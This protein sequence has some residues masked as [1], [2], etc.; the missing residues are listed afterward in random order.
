MPVIFSVAA[1]K[2]NSIDHN[3]VFNV[4]QNIVIGF[5]CTHTNNQGSGQNLGDGIIHPASIGT[6]GFDASNA[7]GTVT[8]NTPITEATP[9]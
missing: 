7:F 1:I 2:I 8:S 3:S 9:V 4:G 6:A 5:S